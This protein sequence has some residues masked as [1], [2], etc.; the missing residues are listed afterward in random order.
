MKKILL[1]LLIAVLILPCVFMF[2][3]CSVFTPVE[4]INGRDGT[5]GVT[6]YIGTNGNWWI[7]ETDTGILALGQ[8]G[9]T[10]ANGFTPHIGANGN[11][12][13]NDFDTGVRSEAINGKTPYILDGYWW[14][15]ENNTHI[16]AQGQNGD[17]PFIGSNG[18]WWIGIYDTG[19]F[20]DVGSLMYQIDILTNYI[21]ALNEKISYLESLF[22]P[23]PTS[24]AV[25]SWQTIA[26][27]SSC[28]LAQNF[29]NVGDEKQI[30]LQDG[31]IITVVIL[32]FNH[33]DLSSGLGKAGISIGM[34][35]LL[36]DGTVANVTNTNIGGW[37]DSY[38]RNT[39]MTE[40]FDRLPVT[41]QNLVK[42]VNK[43]STIGGSNTNTVVT[44]D[45]IWLL[46]RVELDGTDELGYA[47][48]GTQYEYWADKNTN[49]DREKRKPD[50]LMQNGMWRLRSASTASNTAFIIINPNGSLNVNAAA[51]GDMGISFGFAI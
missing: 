50:G 15:G 27:V 40:I 48:E 16:L 1:P 8:N 5:N 39:T 36:T 19:V 33:D 7:G 29:Y 30:M 21:L 28:G 25:D 18:N 17:T 26:N 2:A 6:P 14:I 34:K 44:A 45:K 11:W 42:T 24:F 13:I 23:A 43:T 31:E 3:G 41:L 49:A 20:A 46:S 4:T 9:Q 32:G 38:M 47:D 51:M 37:A 12:W 22:T 35:A 10:G